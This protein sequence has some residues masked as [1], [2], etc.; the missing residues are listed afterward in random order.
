MS[1]GELQ[2][3]TGGD[4]LSYVNRPIGFIDR[5]GEQEYPAL[6]AND[7]N[8]YHTTM[9]GNLGGEFSGYIDWY[10]RSQ[11]HVIKWFHDTSK[12][13]VGVVKREYEDGGLEVEVYTDGQRIAPDSYGEDSTHR[14]Y[15]YNIRLGGRLNYVKES[16]ADPDSDY[17]PNY[18]SFNDFPEYADV[19]NDGTYGCLLEGDVTGIIIPFDESIDFNPDTRIDDSTLRGSFS[20]TITFNDSDPWY[21]PR[22]ITRSNPMIFGKGVDA[23]ANMSDWNV[24]DILRFF[25]GNLYQALS[26]YTVYFKGLCPNRLHVGELD[27]YVVNLYSGQANTNLSAIPFNL[28]LTKDKSQAMRYLDDGSVPSDAF[29]YPLNWQSPPTYENDTAPDVPDDEPNDNTPGD[30]SRDITPN[31]PVVPSYTPSMLSNYN[32]YWLSVPDYS[33][34]IQWFWND[35]GAIHDFDDIIAKIEGLYNDVASAVLLVR[36]FPVDIG[37]IGGTGVPSS[38]KLGMIEKQGTVDTISQSSPPAVRDIGHVHISKKY[39]SFCD[40]APYTQLSLYLPFH[41]FVDL[42]IDI[43]MGHD[44]YVKGIYDY[45]TGT[46][47]YLLYYDNQ[48]LINSFIAKFAVDIPITLQTKNDRDSATFQNVSSVVGGLIGAGTGIAS[49]N[50]IGMAVGVTQGVGAINS[51]NASAPMNVKGTVGETGAL[52]SPPQCAIILRRPTI[53]ASDKVSSLS[54]WKNNVGQLCGYGYT[55]SGLR[56]KGFTVVHSP[57]INFTKSIPLQSEVDEIYDYLS[58]GVIL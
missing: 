47:Q 13:V 25:A 27:D 39:K 40:L 58:K 12:R 9:R 4:C 37:W 51:A 41:G 7:F 38:I 53:Q 48:F 26:D 16:P 29:L 43:L 10:M 23:L 45:L 52:Y 5:A 31:L 35:I 42:D 44:L 57:R 8:I 50:P 21:T 56:G 46:I 36:Y 24:G 11:L 19:S 2:K 33:S 30:N 6:I 1:M 18:Q 55:L 20:P 49:G 54:T 14:Q 22:V 15:N 34:F 3:V 28:I 32:W 17:V